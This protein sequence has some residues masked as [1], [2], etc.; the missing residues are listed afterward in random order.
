M[1]AFDLRDA[2]T[3][4]VEQCEGRER[5]GAA[6]KWS[7]NMGRKKTRGDPLKRA[8]A[9]AVGRFDSR[10]RLALAST[11]GLQVTSAAAAAASCTYERSDAARVDG[12]PGGALLIRTGKSGCGAV[13]TAKPMASAAAPMSRD[14]LGHSS[15]LRSMA[16]VIGGNVIGGG[17]VI[18]GK[19][20]RC[21]RRVALMKGE[22]A[23]A[24]AA[25]SCEQGMSV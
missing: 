3:P 10:G 12:Q 8:A 21:A 4:G 11:I 14:E 9:G 5:R 17:D 19:P 7:G 25:D 16:S 2:A 1:Y 22:A 15:R 23:D 24:P 6:R 18:G 20:N 13:S